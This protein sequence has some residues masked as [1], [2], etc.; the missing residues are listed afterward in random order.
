MSLWENQMGMTTSSWIVP[1]SESLEK[2]LAE[3]RTSG[4]MSLWTKID[5]STK[6]LRYAW[7]MKAAK[8]TAIE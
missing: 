2:Y 1:E 4:I 8:K 6:Y 7:R 3:N 5:N